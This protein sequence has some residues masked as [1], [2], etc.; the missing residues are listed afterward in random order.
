MKTPSEVNTQG[1]RSKYSTSIKAV[2]RTWAD[3][4]EN[5]RI[6]LTISCSKRNSKG[7]IHCVASFSTALV[8]PWVVSQNPLNTFVNVGRLEWIPRSQ[9]E[10]PKS[11][12]TKGGFKEGVPKNVNTKPWSS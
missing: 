7:K 12:H 4:S 8:E 5:T 2:M 11:V 3:R 10:P 9:Q 1:L 6:T